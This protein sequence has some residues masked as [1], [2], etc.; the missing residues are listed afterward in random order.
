[1]APLL[2]R[3]PYYVLQVTPAASREEIQ[4]AF[5]KLTPLHHPDLHP[6]KP[7]SEE[8]MKEIL[9]AYEFLSDGDKRI[10]YDDQAFLQLRELSS[11]TDGATGAP[12]PRK[13]SI[14]KR[15]GL[16]FRSQSP[17]GRREKEL[18]RNGYSF[19]SSRNPHT[20][21][22]AVAEFNEVLQINP[23]CVEAIYNQG[24]IF[25]WWGA[26]LDAWMKFVK[27]A[28]LE[29]AYTDARIMVEVLRPY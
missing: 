22:R 8:R 29:P 1:M 7:E 2:T 25:Y 16:W 11:G 13:L 21:S 20:W 27:V 28:T 9:R 26:F 23:I 10:S 3:D 12:A 4:Q 17:S 14:L 5:V 24:I 15:L 19:A 6:M 18:F